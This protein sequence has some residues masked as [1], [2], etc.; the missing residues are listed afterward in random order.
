VFVFCKIMKHELSNPYNLLNLVIYVQVKHIHIHGN[1]IVQFNTLKKHQ[2]VYSNSIK[3]N[4]TIMRLDI[5]CEYCSQNNR[6]HQV[7]IC[8]SFSKTPL[9][10]A[11]VFLCNI[12]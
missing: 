1:K 3:T 12:I 4:T 7:T 5:T 2:Y 8:D 6:Q 9:S 10:W 11:L